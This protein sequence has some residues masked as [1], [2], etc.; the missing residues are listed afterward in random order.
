MN[1]LAPN[2]TATWFGCEETPSRSNVSKVSTSGVDDKIF[3]RSA[4]IVEGGQVVVM[5]SGR[6]GCSR[7]VTEVGCG[8]I[9]RR[10]QDFTSSFFLISPSPS[11]SPIYAFLIK[12]NV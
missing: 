9:P 3:V 11:A 7:T 5:L 6:D 1:C 2:M 4:A 12:Q 10:S 8:G